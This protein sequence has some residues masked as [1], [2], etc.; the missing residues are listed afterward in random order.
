MSAKW[1]RIETDFVDHPKVQRLAAAIQDD[2]SRAGWFVLRVWSW[3]SRFCPTGHVQDCDRAAL[4][5]AAGWRGEAGELVNAL[6]F[7]GFLETNKGGGFDA[8]DWADH[9][10]RVATNAQKERERKRAYRLKAAANVPR[11]NDGTLDGTKPGRPAQR[12]VTERDGTGRDVKQQ[13]PAAPAP[14]PLF[15]LEGEQRKETPAQLRAAWNELT[16]KPIARW[17]SGREELALKALARR[18][19]EQWREVFRR[20]G[21][22]EFCKGTGPKKWVANI[23]WALRDEGPKPES[24]MKILEG[25]F[26]GAQPSEAD[27]AAAA[28][29][30]C[31][32]PDCN[33][34]APTG[35]PDLGVPCCHEHATEASRWC[36]EQGL[37]PWVHARQ[38]L[39]RGFRRAS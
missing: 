39:E 33:R 8:H 16:S 10:G 23:D 29:P 28:L 24:A 5:G 9:Q 26:D 6:V 12:D 27:A 13:Q 21:A 22:S 25:A 35:W 37:E 15:E 2:E 4:E 18:P 7:V 31:A 30:T 20:I 1:M 38:W 3:L 14:V 11:D 36:N 32:A 19:L 17:H 34:A